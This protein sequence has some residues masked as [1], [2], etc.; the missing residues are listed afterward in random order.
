MDFFKCVAQICSP[1]STSS[2]RTQKGDASSGSGFNRKNIRS[3]YDLQKELGTGSYGSVCKGKRKVDGSIRAIKTIGKAS[4]G[5]KCPN[6]DSESIKKL[7]QEVQIMKMLDHPGIIKLH[8]TFEDAKNIYLV[9]ELADGGEL[10]E[11]I[12]SAGHFKE[13]QAASGMKQMLGAI[14]YMHKNKI[15]HRDLKPENFIFSSKAAI[16]ANVLKLIDFGLSASITPG[17]N[18]TTKAGTPYYVAPQVLEGSYNESCDIWSCGVIMFVLL[19]GYPPFYSEQDKQ[20]LK[21]VTIGK[22]HYDKHDWAGVSQDSKNLIDGMLI[23]NQH[24]RY[25]AEQAYNDVWIQKKAPKAA[26]V[27]LPSGMLDKLRSF[28]SANKLKKAALHVIAGLLSEDKIKKLTE[29]FKTLDTNGDGMLSA[30]ELQDGLKKTGIT[31]FPGDLQQIFQ[32]LDT[33]QSG[34]IDY[35]EFLAAALDQRQYIQEDVCWS[36][37][38]AFD[39]D[40]NG[41]ISQSELLEVLKAEGIS[42][43]MGKQAVLEVMEE[44]DKDG[45]GEIDFQEFMAMMRHVATK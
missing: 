11:R 38:C 36:A 39:K 3:C 18:F 5:G 15:C 7:R 21:L 33:D 10:F 16:D 4:A 1:K 27:P 22:Y 43:C 30:A 29:M 6:E 41:R 25:T 24:K 31:Q 26:D 28:R 12:V 17:K 2:N 9:M 14:L 35:S 40:G 44:V 8:E 20:V 45:N 42:T 37:F 19:C 34:A 23:R 13:T 32:D